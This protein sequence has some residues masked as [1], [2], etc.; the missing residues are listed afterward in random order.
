MPSTRKQKAKK[1]KSGQSDVLSDL[2]DMIAVLWNFCANEF[3][4]NSKR[5]S[6]TDLLC[7]SHS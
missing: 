4:E 1:E 2:E 7:K 3:E 6:G 5:G